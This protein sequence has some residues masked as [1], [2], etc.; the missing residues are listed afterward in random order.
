MSAVEGYL[1]RAFSTRISTEKGNRR[2]IVFSALY[3][4]KHFFGGWWVLSLGLM[5][6]HVAK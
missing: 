4:Q 5:Y 6:E 3:V 1:G 2:D